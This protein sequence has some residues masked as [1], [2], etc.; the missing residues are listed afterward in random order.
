M[1]ADAVDDLG[2]LQ[3]ECL[4]HGTHLDP[5]APERICQL[6]GN[7]DGLLRCF[8]QP[9][10]FLGHHF[11]QRQQGLTGVIGGGGGI[12]NLIAD[13]LG[14]MSRA[15]GC[16]E[17]RGQH[18]FRHGLGPASL[19]GKLLTLA[20]HVGRPEHE[21]GRTDCQQAKHC[22]REC[23]ILQ[24]CHA[25]AVA[26]RKRNRTHRPQ[27]GHDKRDEIDRPGRR[28]IEC[29]ERKRRARRIDASLG[30]G[31]GRATGCDRRPTAPSIQG[32]GHHRIGKIV[33][34]SAEVRRQGSLPGLHARL[35]LFACCGRPTLGATRGQ[36]Y[37][38][39]AARQTAER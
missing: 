4:D 37:P 7:L 23:V 24:R 21:D 30:H 17:G 19:S 8:G 16:D 10:G 22:Q 31:C 39:W 11:T 29:V 3:V 20:K 34:G 14:D 38:R 5:L 26:Y 28:R 15:G 35:G 13:N 6:M 25:C 27:D 36:E 1:L 18:V 33:R 2:G 9:L 32:R 12:Q